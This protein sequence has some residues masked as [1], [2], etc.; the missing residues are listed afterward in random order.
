MALMERIFFFL[1]EAIWFLFLAENKDLSEACGST[2]QSHHHYPTEVSEPST[3]T[4]AAACS[5]KIQAIVEPASKNQ[6]EEE[7]KIL[8]YILLLNFL[9][10]K[11]VLIWVQGV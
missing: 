1:L 6:A 8:P 7:V 3:G 11:I 2:T 4:G 9:W 5:A 10:T